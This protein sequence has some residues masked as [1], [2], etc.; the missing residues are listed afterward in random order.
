MR[1]SRRSAK[2]HPAPAA[3]RCTAEECTKQSDVIDEIETS[4]TVI[5]DELNQ[6][7]WGGAGA[8]RSS[9]TSE[10]PESFLRRRLWMFP[11]DYE[12]KDSSE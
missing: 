11:D 3:D 12:A 7:Y 4:W 10:A 1:S 8:S 6:D 9:S 5:V 2:A